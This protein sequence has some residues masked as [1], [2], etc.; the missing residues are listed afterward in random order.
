M[1]LDA[2]NYFIRRYIKAQG[3]ILFFLFAAF[4]CPA[5][6][7]AIPIRGVAGD[8][9]A[10]L[11]LGQPNF[12]ELKPNEA[13]NQQVFIPDG[14][15]VDRVSNP[16]RLY[17]WDSGNSRI[18][19][20]SNIANA[21]T[22]GSNPGAIPL[23]A[24]IV[25]GQPDF[26]HTACNGDSNMQNYPNPAQPNASCLCGTSQE[27][28]SPL[29]GGVGANM[30]VD[31]Q[32]NLY[33]PDYF[34]NRVLR[35]NAPVASSQAA[36]YVWGQGSG[37]SNFTSGYNQCSPASSTSLC[38]TNSARVSGVAVDSQGNL[39]VADSGHN[40]VLRF[41]VVGGVPQATADLVLGQSNFTSTTG[42]SGL[43]DAN[44]MTRPIAVRVDNAG[45]VYVADDLDNA[46]PN[47]CLFHG[48]VLVY[49]APLS[50]GMAASG[51]MTNYLSW[52]M[53]MEFDPSSGG[54]WVSDFC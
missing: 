28:I 43:N 48:R 51:I 11:V 41:P 50:S 12:A 32:G 30:A 5:S 21:N 24:D 42:A 53:G 2:T 49:K 15:F 6:S 46:N 36:A 40:R 1:M 22:S 26:A 17:V 7:N 37:L 25:L 47:A 14:A 31:G 34:N 23:G 18:L 19:G 13:T 45:N 10:D 3:L 8:L 38:L 16:Q 52:T 4:L 44:H 9:W 54:L 27:G 20:F 39:W 35:Y 29:E 33:V